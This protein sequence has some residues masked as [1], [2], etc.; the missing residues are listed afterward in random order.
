MPV[1]RRIS[2]KY[3]DATGGGSTP[4]IGQLDIGPDFGEGAGN[5]GTTWKANSAIG[6]DKVNLAGELGVNSALD[7]EEVNLA[8]NL[9]AST[10]LDL[11]EVNL[12]GDFG[13]S[14]AIAGS[15]VITD[16]LVDEDTYLDEAAGGTNFGSGTTAIGK[17]D[18][19]DGV[20]D[21]DKNAY[22]AWDLTGFAGTPDTATINITL[23]DD[24][25]SG[26]TAR[27]EVYTD[28]SQ[29]LDES[30]ATWDADEQPAGTLRQTID[31]AT[32][33]TPTQFAL[34]LDATTRANMFGNWLY[35]RIIGTADGVGVVI[36][37]A[38][39]K[40]SASDP[41]LDLEITL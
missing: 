10:V 14:A 4:T 31:Q 32:T 17:N 33:T 5:D 13:V 23:N 18:T 38:Q 3:S 26:D 39:T 7:L 27:I 35:L 37:T 15:V 22:L 19:L 40:E 20:V 1:R 30:T 9:G 11:E 41:T 2:A 8:G 25:V 6:L 21:D 24:A 28:P 36:I 29:P 16:M 12:A 34:T